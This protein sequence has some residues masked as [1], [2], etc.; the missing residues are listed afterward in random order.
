MKPAESGATPSAPVRFLDEILLY[1][2]QYALFY[3]LMYLADQKAGFLADLG[4]TTLLAS[5]VVQTMVLVLWGRLPL[6]RFLG[7]LITPAIYAVFEIGGLSAFFLDIGHFNFWFFSVLIGGLQ[8][9][10]LLAR[11]GRLR[12]SLEFLST[13]F[14]VVIFLVVYFYFD[15]RVTHEQMVAAGTLAAADLPAH[16]RISTYGVNLAEFLA[17]AT[18]VYVV[19]GGIL[20]AFTLARGRVKILRL[21]ER[22]SELFGTYVDGRVRD[23]IMGTAGRLG[24]TKEVAILFSDIRNFTTVTEQSPA[25]GVVGMLNAYFS[26]WDRVSRAHGGIIDKF[27]GDA[28]MIIFEP[29]AGGDPARDAVRCAMA[30]FAGLE[31]LRADLGARG[32]PVLPDIG[33]G[34]AYGG[35]ILG[36]IGSAHRRNYTAIGDNVNTASRLESACKEFGKH[37]IVS[38]TVFDR[39]EDAVQARFTPLGEIPLKGKTVTLPVFGA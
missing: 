9:L 18:H 21:S 36:D 3:I 7:S 11:P 22:I 34:I 38:K 2:G 31:A 16:L 32:L 27:I 8:A 17:D 14:S 24:E 15:V 12:F 29:R 13:F 35:V 10:A 39:L 6:V 20:L 4:H 37:L 26:E 1:S 5:L 33:V 25:A 23:R 19:I 28:V 30:M